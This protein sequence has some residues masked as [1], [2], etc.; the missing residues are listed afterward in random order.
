[1]CSCLFLSLDDLY[2]YYEL[3]PVL[4]STNLSTISQME[5]FDDEYDIGITA[6]GYEYR[7]QLQK[8]HYVREIKRIMDSTQSSDINNSFDG[9]SDD[10][11]DDV[12]L[13]KMKKKLS[14][15]CL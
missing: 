14:Q 7:M 8:E 1:M 4:I 5:K 6:L 2:D 12:R 9:E 13:A 10:N 11:S 15:C 3:T